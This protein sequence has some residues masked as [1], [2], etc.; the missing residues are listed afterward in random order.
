MSE[1]IELYVWELDVPGSWFV[2]HRW[3]L[4]YEY[5]NVVSVRDCPVSRRT[6]PFFQK[7][8]GDQKNYLHLPSVFAS[9]LQEYQHNW[10][11]FLLPLVT[12]LHILDIAVVIQ[13]ICF[14][15]AIP[16]LFS[17]HLYNKC[18]LHRSLHSPLPSLTLF[19]LP[20]FWAPCEQSK[21]GTARPYKLLL[22]FIVVVISIQLFFSIVPTANWSRTFSQG[23]I[24]L[25]AA[26]LS[27]HWSWRGGLCSFFSVFWTNLFGL[28]VWISRSLQQF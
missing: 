10:R 11:I 8:L 23:V 1:I 25:T 19:P 16:D 9:D 24:C 14:L 21:R 12:T 15:F 26:R 17:A 4:D 22:Q 5:C 18:F 3:D 13:R 27:P 6:Y 20:S 2:I 28:F 7:A